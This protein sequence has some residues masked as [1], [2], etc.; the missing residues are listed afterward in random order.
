MLIGYARIST[1]SKKQDLTRQLD[2]LKEY[3]CERIYADEFTGKNFNRPQYNL[4]K[5]TLRKGDIVVVHE[6][7]R[8]GRNKVSIVKELNWL[9]DNSIRFV[10]LNIP[11]TLVDTNDNL[12]LDM[13]NNLV[14]EIYAT[15]AQ[16][17]I[18]T[19]SKRVKETLGT[20]PRDN[21][22]KIY[23]K[24]TGNYIGRPNIQFPKE[25][26]GIIKLVE[27]K[28]ITNTKAMEMLQLKRTSY[29]KLMKQY[30]EL[31]TVN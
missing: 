5:Q 29:Y 10:A 15:I 25:W 19:K 31:K 17:E 30:K 23:S 4:M 16:Q 22:G 20:L 21:N 27:A 3:G 7:D 11:T 18:E 9:R 12:I 1:N 26:D 24:K 28:E 2:S 13:I 6:L 14:I 8:L